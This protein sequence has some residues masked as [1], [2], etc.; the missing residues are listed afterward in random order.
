MTASTLTRLASL[1]LAAR[2]AHSQYML[3]V[4]R[5]LTS[6]EFPGLGLRS[7]CQSDLRCLPLRC[8]MGCLVYL[9]CIGSCRDR[10]L[11]WFR[12]QCMGQCA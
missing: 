11:P 2:F 4:N 9:T 1:P 10:H 12:W 8:A 3:E 5:L 6:I 7:S